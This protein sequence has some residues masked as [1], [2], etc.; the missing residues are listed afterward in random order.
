MGID[1]LAGND[2]QVLFPSGDVELAVEQK[3]EVPGPVPVVVECLRRA[4]GI[5]VITVEQV[6][7][8]HLNL[9]DLTFGKDRIGS[10]DSDAGSG[11]CAPR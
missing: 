4:V 6:V 8:L 1:V 3:A 10:D 7:T 9:T 11:Q 5:V 2:D